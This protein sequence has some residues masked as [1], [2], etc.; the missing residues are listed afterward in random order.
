MSHPNI[1]PMKGEV[2]KAISILPKPFHKIT[3]HPA[4]M[5][6]A[7]IIPPTRACEELLGKPKYQV[8]ISQRMALLSAARITTI[9]ILLEAT[10]SLPIVFATVGIKVAKINAPENSATAVT[11]RATRGENAREEIIVETTLLE[12]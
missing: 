5:T 11:P 2:N 7:P 12:S 4:S 10:T 8:N 9:L 3:F 6:T 1:K